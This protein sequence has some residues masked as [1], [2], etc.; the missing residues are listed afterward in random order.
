MTAS[1]Y[2]LAGRN[3]RIRTSDPHISQTPLP[4]PSSSV[5]FAPPRSSLIQLP[6]A[7]P[8]SAAP[9]FQTAAASGGLPPATA[10]SP[11]VV[12]QSPTGLHQP[13]LQARQQPGLDS[14]R[15]HQPA[16]Q[17]PQVVGV[18]AQ[19]QPHFVAPEAMA[20]EGQLDRLLAFLD[21][22]FRRSPL[23]VE[24]Y[25]RPAVGLQI[26][27]DESH[28]REQLSEMKLHLGYHAPR[29]IYALRSRDKAVVGKSRI[30]NDVIRAP[31]VREGL[32]RSRI[33]VSRQKL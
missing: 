2:R 31:T 6:P 16:P 11:R 20:T 3:V 21:P 27:D 13:L 24:P 25:D 22:L 30:I 26:G 15:Q 19:P 32:L 29:C 10:S 8:Q 4:A 14:L 28:A 1:P 33:P 23:V 7:A 9:C 18:P 17:V 5:P 12:H